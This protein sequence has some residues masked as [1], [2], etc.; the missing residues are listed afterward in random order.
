M[1]W[2]LINYKEKEEKKITLMQVN[3]QT[4]KHKQ[5]HKITKKLTQKL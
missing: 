2:K 5:Y 3:K 1:F 4:N